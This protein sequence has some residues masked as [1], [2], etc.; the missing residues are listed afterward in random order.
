MIVSSK[1]QK[2]KDIRRFLRCKGDRAVLEGPH[3]VQEAIASGLELELVLATPTFLASAEAR[4]LLPNLAT[5][6]STV[7]EQILEDLC[8]A[9]S[10]KGILAVVHLSRSGL[11]AL[12]TLPETG[13]YLYGHQLQDPGNL[14]ALART[15]EAF[16]VSALLLSPNSVHPNH[17][18]A[19]RASAGSL[20]RQP[21]AVGVEPAE[22]VTLA[23]PVEPT[24][25][26]LVP[27][28]GTPLE[29]FRS[30]LPLLLFVGSE[31][32]GLPDSILEQADALLTIPIAEPVESLNVTVA[33]SVVL[34]QLWQ[35]RAQRASPLKPP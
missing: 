21:V 8:D 35:Q 14:G 27:R 34:W 4:K 26:A 31:G 28:G 20:L 32:G 17:P 9:D 18:R 29:E 30:S 23:L 1:N 3:L 12:P 2:V 5:P 19:L 16:G 24:S 6:V 15:A 22:L 7:D 25:V 33:V 11:G 13:V 10:P